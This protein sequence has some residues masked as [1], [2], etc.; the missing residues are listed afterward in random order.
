MMRSCVFVLAAVVSV[1]APAAAQQPAPLPRAFVNLDFG[2]Q[3]QSQDLAQTAE[4]PLYD[5]TGSWTA[6]HAL[7]GGPLFSVGAGYR[8]FGN[9]SLG[10]TYTQRTKTT[11]D[12]TV[13]AAIP[14]PVFTDTLR[15]GAGAVAGLEH[16]ERAVHLQALWH[17]PV[18]VEFD[19]TLFAGPSFF[20]VRDDLVA[21][22]TPFEAGGDYSTVDLQTIGT[23]RQ[24]NSGM[25]F[26]I[27]IDS[28]YMI[29]RNA[30]V[31]ATVR[32]TRASVDL[33]PPAG[34]GESGFTID[35]GGLEVAAGLRFRF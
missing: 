21:T 18:T 34:T 30:G 13:D 3:T 16:T 12:V 9:L 19:L 22:V 15:S 24:R 25:G 1:A 2:Y 11:R 29:M 32:Y 26:N 23:S 28:S 8:L 5:E 35:A 7:E 4:F 33:T 27:G 20:N 17:V 31:G 10:A 6:E 14:S